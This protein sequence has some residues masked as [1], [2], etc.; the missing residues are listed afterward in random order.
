MSVPGNEREAF[1]GDGIC[2]SPNCLD[3]RAE[4][5]ALPWLSRRASGQAQ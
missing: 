3:P 2:S 5:G 4:P 1:G